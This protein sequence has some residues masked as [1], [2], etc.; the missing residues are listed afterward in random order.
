MLF[1][2]GSTLG[3]NFTGTLTAGVANTLSLTRPG[4]IARLSFAGTAGQTPPA[5]LSAAVTTP[6][7]GRTELHDHIM[8]GDVMRMRQVP[9]VAL[10]PLETVTFAPLALH[11]MCFDPQLPMTVGSTVPVTF[12]F[13]NASDTETQM[14]KL[15]AAVVSIK[16]AA[17]SPA[18]SSSPA[19]AGHNHH[20]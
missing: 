5:A 17:M 10:K 6:A 4:Q 11:V 9:N 7:C 16:D 18:K 1:R 19:P 12:T 20:H 15:S 2:S 13:T 14:I 3:G 8:D